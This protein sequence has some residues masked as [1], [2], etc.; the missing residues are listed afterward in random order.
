MEITILSANYV[1]EPGVILCQ[2][3]AG[4]ETFPYITRDGTGD[5]NCQIVWDAYIASGIKP[6]PVPDPIEA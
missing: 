3:S 1:N 6:G 2:C 5:T 4:G